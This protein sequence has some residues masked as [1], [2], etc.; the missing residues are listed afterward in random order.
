VF[1]GNSGNS[2]SV[3]SQFGSKCY[4]VGALGRDEKTQFIKNDLT[5]CGI[6]YSLCPIYDHPLP[7][8]YIV[9]SKK[10]GSRTIIHVRGSMPEVSS[11]TFIETIEKVSNPSDA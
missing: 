3:L 4:F 5:R 8:S 10:T 1:L 2:L 7:T 9:V 11:D 6:D